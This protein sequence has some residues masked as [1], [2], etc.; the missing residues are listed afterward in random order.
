MASARLRCCGPPALRRGSHTRAGV[1]FCTALP[2]SPNHALLGTPH[3]LQDIDNLPASEARRRLEAFRKRQQSAAAAKAA[4]AAA[5]ATAADGGGEG[6]G[7][8]LDA[9]A[10]AAA[11]GAFEGAISEAFEGALKFY[12]SEE[13][14]EVRAGRSRGIK[15][16]SRERAPPS[17]PA[18]PPPYPPPDPTPHRMTPHS[19]IHQLLRYLDQLIREEGERRWLPPD[20]ADNAAGA[21]A[22]GALG[23]AAGGPGGPGAARVLGSAN[24]LFLKIR[25]SLTRCVK[26]VSRGQTLLG[27]A[28]AFKVRG[29]RRALLRGVGCVRGR[30]L[31]LPPRGGGRGGRGCCVRSLGAH[32][33]E[34]Y[35]WP[36]CL[37]SC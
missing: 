9:A 19:T 18:C 37:E 15:Q 4:A 3:A 7:A 20:E 17:L 12:V 10:A 29:A 22:A 27:L 35:L 28:G 21:G 23:P 6:G 33:R 13:Q 32:R 14:K 25:A 2:R 30:P 24:A 5:A 34:A 11:R 8:A 31:P 16:P 36:A 1:L 26:L